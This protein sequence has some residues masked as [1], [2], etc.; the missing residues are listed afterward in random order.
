MCKRASGARWP[1]LN[2]GPARFA[3]KRAQMTAPATKDWPTL[4]RRAF[5]AAAGAWFAVPSLSGLAGAATRE[6]ASQKLL[7]FEHLHTGEALT[8]AY[9][10]DGLY[11]AEALPRVARLLRDHYTDEVHSIDPTLL[12][13]LH[14]VQ[15]RTGSRAPYQVISGYRSPRTNARLRAAGHRV[16]ARS[17]HMEGKA[18]DIRLADVPTATLRDV[19]WGLQRGG[20]G[21]YSRTDFVHL[22]VGRV[23]RW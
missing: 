20:V 8:L 3:P 1:G 23:R 15:R 5:L 13:L 7:S 10:E 2:Y 22:D 16:G 19:A 4:S 12:D 21:Y 6:Q 11:F 14:E 17:L 9:A 18:I